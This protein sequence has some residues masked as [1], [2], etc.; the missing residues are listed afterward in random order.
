MKP[1]I[2]RKE[3]GTIV[4]KVTVPAAE[5]EKARKKV[6]EELT[7]QVSAPGFR[8]G[9]VPS[10][11]AKQRIPKDLLQEEVLKQI[12]PEEYNKAV[13]EAD[14]QP[15]I[16]PRL[17][18]ETFDEGT[19]LVFE[20]ETAEA[21]K[22]E[23]GDYKKAVKE[24]TAKSKIAVPGKN[25]EEQKPNL[26]DVITA[27]LK[28]VKTTIPQILKEQ[29]ANRLLSQLLDELKSLGLNL[30]QYLASRGKTAD[31]IRKEYEEKAEKDLTLEF[32]L[33]TVADQEKI[34]VEPA[35]IENALGTVQDPKQREEIAKN[36]YFLANIIRQQKTLDFLASL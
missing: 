1:E 28:S 8:K 13:K 18:I 2:T 34:T 11:M 5:V 23:V 26:D 16:S 7:K 9:K 10:N 15:I 3:D 12:V 4:L 20:A 36:P 27:A 6:E 33:R 30:D 17:H 29:E 35:D 14:L 24:V 19:G 25:E 21:P 32:F 22:V 31:E